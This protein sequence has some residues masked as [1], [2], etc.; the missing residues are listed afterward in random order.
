[1]GQGSTFIFTWPKK[2]VETQNASKE[3][4]KSTLPA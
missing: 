3:L 4:E 2:V 1:V